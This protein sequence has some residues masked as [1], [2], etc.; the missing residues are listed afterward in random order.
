MLR[1]VSWTQIRAVPECAMI[2]VDRGASS[3]Y[4]C[5]VEKADAVY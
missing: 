3:E 4:S 2:V 5:H 1:S